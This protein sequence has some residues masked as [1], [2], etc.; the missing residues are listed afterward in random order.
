[1]LRKA[2]KVVC[3]IS[4]EAV[5]YTDLAN[6]SSNKLY[7]MGEITPLL[8]QIHRKVC[9][10]E[11]QNKGN[12]FFAEEVTSKTEF[13]LAVIHQTQQNAYFNCKQF[14]NFGETHSQVPLPK[15]VN[16]WSNHTYPDNFLTAPILFHMHKGNEIC[17]LKIQFYS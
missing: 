8:K 3:I 9:C 12:I 4:F 11:A 6:G 1:M 5:S 15:S 14:I 13:Q 16:D 7:Q 10:S 17:I 2:V